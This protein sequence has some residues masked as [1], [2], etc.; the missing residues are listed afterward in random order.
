MLWLFSAIFIG[1]TSLP[2]RSRTCLSQ[3]GRI[4]GQRGSEQSLSVVYREALAAHFPLVRLILG[5][6]VSSK[7]FPPRFARFERH[8]MLPM[9]APRAIVPQ[10][11][12]YRCQDS[13]I[14]SKP[15]EIR[16]SIIVLCE[17]SVFLFQGKKA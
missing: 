16:K 17:S 15:A 8:L 9:Q 4:Y 7:V 5:A 1:L 13:A 10:T 14:V 2:H 11:S 3:G 6:M 12:E